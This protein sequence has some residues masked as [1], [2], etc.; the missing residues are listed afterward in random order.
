MK[1]F[2]GCLESVSILVLRM[3]FSVQLEALAFYYAY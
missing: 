1:S 3:N 2:K